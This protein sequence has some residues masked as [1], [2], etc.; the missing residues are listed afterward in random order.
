MK[1]FVCSCVLIVILCISNYVTVRQLERSNIKVQVASGLAK[2]LL[3]DG[4]NQKTQ[5]NELDTK[6]QV[7]LMELGG[8]KSSLGNRASAREL[9][10]LAEIDTLKEIIVARDINTCEQAAKFHNRE[11]ELL[12][13]IDEEKGMW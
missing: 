8:L 1:T 9:E 2:D 12:D 6:Y 10:L 7:V 11:M 5:F 13:V 3:R 4:E